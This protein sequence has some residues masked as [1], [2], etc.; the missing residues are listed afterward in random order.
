MSVIG[1]IMRK[2]V[3]WW[4]EVEA[5]ENKMARTDEAVASANKEAQKI[6]ILAESY[7]ATSLYLN[8]R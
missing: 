7:R 4:R 5:V 3:P 8:R 6:R 2:L 1:D